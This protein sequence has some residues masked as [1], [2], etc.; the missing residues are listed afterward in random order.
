MGLP[1]ETRETI[2]ETIN[3]A[4][5]LGLHTV[6]FSGAVP[7]PGTRYYDLCRR[8]GL[9]TAKSWADWLEGGEQAQVVSYPGLT[10]AEIDAAVDRGLKKFYFRPAYM[11]RFLFQTRNRKDLYRKLRGAKNFFSYLFSKRKDK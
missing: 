7:F 8:E 9:L 11:I 2:E 5:E 1:G 3:F 4:L 10:K 6:Q